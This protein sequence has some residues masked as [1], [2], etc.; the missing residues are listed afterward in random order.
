MGY[1]IPELGFYS[2]AMMMVLLTGGV[3]LSIVGTGNL[4]CIVAALIMHTG[5]TQNL[6]G[7]SLALN[8]AGAIAAAI[9]IGLI[10]GFVNG[11]IVA[12]FGITPILVTMAT[13]SIYTGIGIIITRGEAVSKVP[14]QFLYFGTNTFMYV[15][16]PLWGLIIALIITAVILNKTKYGFEL[17]MIGSNAVASY[18]TGMDNRLILIKTYLYS[19]LISAVCGLEILSR[20]DTAKADYAFTYTFQA[21]LCAVLG[22]TSPTGG[23][24]K[25]SCLTLSLIS[26]QF[27]SRG[28]NMLRLGGYFKEFAWGLLLLLVLS[29]NYIIEERRR[30]K[31]I[32]SVRQNA[33]S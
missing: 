2:I 28:F 17:K 23:F 24:A 14:K 32:V 5:F 4:A 21:I 1:Q 12:S 20:T 27:L 29:V 9:A 30:R 10:C 18:Y 16:I 3:D 22:A 8:I 15:P 6:T 33:A 26:L 19:G 31:S 25:V 7:G 11:F 13:Y